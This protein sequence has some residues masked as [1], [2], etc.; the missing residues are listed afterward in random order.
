MWCLKFSPERF[1]GFPGVFVK[2]IFPIAK[3]CFC[4]LSVF[5]HQKKKQ[6]CPKSYHFQGS[7]DVDALAPGHGRVGEAVART[8]PARHVHTLAPKVPEGFRNHEDGVVGQC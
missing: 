1:F 7:L 4:T 3:D 8:P 2:Y 5:L 6:S